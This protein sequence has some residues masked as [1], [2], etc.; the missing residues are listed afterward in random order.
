[1]RVTLADDKEL[2]CLQKIYPVGQFV[3]AGFAGSVR[4][5]F[6][7]IE[8]LTNLLSD[9]GPD[10]A[11]DPQAICEWWQQDAR[12]VFNPF[13]PNERSLR[14]E[15]LMVATHPTENNGPGTRAYGYIFRSPQFIPEPILIH[16]IGAIGSGNGVIECKSA[17]DKISNDHDALFSVMKGEEGTPGGMGTRFG[18]QLTSILKK[19]RPSGVSAHLH[20]CW[21]YR[22]QVIIR[23]NDHSSIGGWTTFASGSGIGQLQ[24]T[25]SQATSLLPVPD[26]W[27]RFEMPK[28]AA[29]WDE[30]VLLLE[31]AGA[32]AAGSVA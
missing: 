32:F 5:G 13:P 17:V 8:T 21:V 25:Q 18:F 24:A 6:A 29:G 16:K 1:V 4:I 28:I 12:D 19:I 26:D 2:D 22:G 27:K 9:A 7:M 14:S 31:A 30:F 23:A 10:R 3:A 15:L 20:Y 11:W